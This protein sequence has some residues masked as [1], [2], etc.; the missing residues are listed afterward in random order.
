M[1]GKLSAW[2]REDTAMWLGH[3]TYL[4]Y[5]GAAAVFITNDVMGQPQYSAMSWA[6]SLAALVFLTSLFAQFTVHGRRLCERCAAS[7]PLDPQRSV[8]RWRLS[9]RLAHSMRLTYALTAVLAAKILLEQVFRPALWLFSLDEAT[10]T[11]L[12]VFAVSWWA[13]GRLQAWCPWCRWGGG[14]DHEESP[15]VPDPAVSR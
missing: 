3:N 6:T 2:D 4:I 9:L 11:V 8:D 1:N 12:G 14:G 10:T 7:A 13:H 5:L 15:Q